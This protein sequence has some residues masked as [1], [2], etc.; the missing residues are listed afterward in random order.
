MADGAVGGPDPSFIGF[1]TPSP[2]S[3]ARIGDGEP[4]CGGR[5]CGGTRTAGSGHQ[6]EPSGDQ[7]ATPAQISQHRQAHAG[8]LFECQGKRRRV[9]HDPKLRHAAALVLHLELE[10]VRPAPKWRVEDAAAPGR[11]RRER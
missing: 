11:R 3:R 6:P 10:S 7:Y 8:Q 1:R 2:P 4:G 9:R 5:A